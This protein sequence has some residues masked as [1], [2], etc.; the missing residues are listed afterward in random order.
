MAR[1][2]DALAQRGV[3]L[4][5]GAGLI[6][7]S[8]DWVLR[9]GLAYYVYALTGSTVASAVMLLASF[10]PQI[11]LS[12]LAGVFVDRWDPKRTM[13]VTNL[14]LAGG[15]LP[16]LLVR[17]PRDVWLVYI[18]MAG[19]G[20][21]QQF[22]TPA[23]QKML[24]LVTNPPHR[25]TV[26]ALY[27]QNRD[28]SRLLGAALGGGLVAA[29]GLV[30]VVIADVASF[31]IA[32]AFCSVLPVA[33]AGRRVLLTPAIVSSVGGRIRELREEWADGLRLSTRESVLRA[34]LIFLAIVSVGEGVM[35]TLFA[36]FV[37]SV[38]HGTGADFGWINA[39]QAAG[40][41]GGGLLAAS[42]GSRLDPVAALPHSAIAFGAVDLI[43]FLYPLV[44]PV[45]WPAAMLIAGAGV[46]GAFML[47]AAMTLMQEHTADRYRGRVFGAL[48]AV[49][50]VA[51]VA[52]TLTAGVLAHVL[53]IVAVLSVQGAGYVVAGILALALLQ[54]P[55]RL[56]PATD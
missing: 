18:V 35:G 45:V 31:L 53:G 11:A 54:A 34:L 38:L 29:G 10:I 14:A 20:A 25:P 26:N 49:E 50:G 37:R 17:H 51:I 43:L 41:I 48:G 6:S 8:G 13:V 22:F 28:A 23:E 39:A 44:W 36:P 16:L 27:G 52:G 2:R 9:V 21:V 19:E 46:A 1:L 30:P 55:Q 40:G 4:L 33:S 42:L 47:T 5:L 15:L 56:A 3:R 12:S 24:P 7:L 32:A